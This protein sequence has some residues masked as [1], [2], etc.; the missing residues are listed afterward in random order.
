MHT[1]RTEK[2][3]KVIAFMQVDEFIGAQSLT[4]MPYDSYGWRS[5][6]AQ[7]VSVASSSLAIGS[8]I[9]Y[10]GHQVGEV[11]QVTYKDACARSKVIKVML[12]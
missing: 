7:G 12:S 1:N 3:H 8:R 11:I 2:H 9:L 5:E 10:V 4:F 6:E